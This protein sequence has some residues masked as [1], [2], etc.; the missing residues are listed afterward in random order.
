MP[1]VGGSETTKE[2]VY[3]WHNKGEVPHMANCGFEFLGGGSPIQEELADVC[4]PGDKFVFRE[5]DYWLSK[6]EVPTTDDL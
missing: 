1:F 5:G 4:C 2:V 3:S 6:V